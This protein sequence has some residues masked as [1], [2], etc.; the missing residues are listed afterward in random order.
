MRFDAAGYSSA[1]VR[2]TARLVWSSSAVGNASRPGSCVPFGNFTRH[3]FLGILRRKGAYVNTTRRFLTS[4]NSAGEKKKLIKFSPE[5][6]QTVRFDFAIVGSFED[7]LRF[8]FPFWNRILVF[9]SKT[10]RRPEC[11]LLK[12]MTRKKNFVSNS[13]L[14]T[15]H[16]A[17]N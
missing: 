10:I 3:S 9:A 2:G 13:T 6:M 5:S 15:L 7:G 16:F 11:L 8:R 1:V 12:I 17:R 4:W 14:S